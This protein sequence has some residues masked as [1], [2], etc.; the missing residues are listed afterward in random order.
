[1]RRIVDAGRFCVCRM[2]KVA[3]LIING[4]KQALRAM[5]IVL[6]TIGIIS[7]WTP[8]MDPGIADR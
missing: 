3:R 8:W 5:P 1:M 7:L 6:L 2:L 4:C